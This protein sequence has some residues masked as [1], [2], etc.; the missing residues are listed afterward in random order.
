MRYHNLIFENGYMEN[1]KDE[2][3][4]LLTISSSI[5]INDVKTSLLVKD[6]R[7]MGYEVNADTILDILN[8]IDIVNSADSK[9]INISTFSPDEE[10]LDIPDFEQDDTTFGGFDDEDENDAVDDSA[11]EKSVRDITK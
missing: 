9:I 2:V 6:L 7:G 8:D 11:I 10:I 5:G 1:L 4:N 3:V